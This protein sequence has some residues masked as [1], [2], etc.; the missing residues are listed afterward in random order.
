MKLFKSIK[1]YASNISRYR[2]EILFL[3]YQSVKKQYLQTAFGLGWAVVQPM[4]YMVTF[5]F[6]FTLGLRGGGPI[7]GFH[8]LLVLFC[9]NMPWLLM[10]GTINGGT[11]IISKNAIL[12]K[13]IKFPVMALPLIEVLSKMYVHI[14]VMGLVIVIFTIA[15]YRPDIYYINFIYYWITLIA[16]LTAISFL[17]SSVSIVVK[18]IPP[19]ISAI[20]L[21][22]FWMTPVLWQPAGMLLMFEKLFNPFYYFILGYQET[23]LYD[24]FFWENIIYDIYIWVIIGIIFMVGLKFFKKIRPIMADII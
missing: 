11:K 13:T 12:V 5:W 18:D 15:G 1:L 16:F 9:S 20:M 19:L 10:S 14:A 17:L 2:N 23:M 21:P 7:N 22:L 3:S 8:Y 24:V 6:F 4:V